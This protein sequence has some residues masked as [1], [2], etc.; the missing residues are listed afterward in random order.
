MCRRKP[1]NK[2]S[3][4]LL[5]DRSGNSFGK[6]H[7][8]DF[9]S[10]Q[11]ATHG[12]TVTVVGTYGYMPPEQ[13]GGKTTPAS[14]LY[15][16]GATLIYL[17]TKTHPAD[18]PSRSGFIRF[19]AESLVSA[20]F[21]TW[22]SYLIQPDVSQRFQSAQLALEALQNEQL[23]PSSHG[24]R[25]K[26]SGSRVILTKTDAQLKIVIPPLPVAQKLRVIDAALRTTAFTCSPLLLG[27]WKPEA[28]LLVAPLVLYI[29]VSFWVNYGYRLFAKIQVLIDESKIYFTYGWLGFK[30]K[31]SSSTKDII[32]LERICPPVSDKPDPINEQLFLYSSVDLWVGNK[33]HSLRRFNLTSVELDWLA[34]E[35]SEWLCLPIQKPG[36]GITLNSDCSS[37]TSAQ[38][39]NAQ[40]SSIE[41]TSSIQQTSPGEL[42]KVNRP[43]NALCYVD[44]DIKTIKISAPVQN[45]VSLQGCACFF[46]LYLLLLV[47][48]GI[49]PVAALILGAAP[50]ILWKIGDHQLNYRSRMA[51]TILQIDRQSISLW[52]QYQFEL[53]QLPHFHRLVARSTI[54]NR[55]SMS[56]WEQFQL[57]QQRYL[58]KK[59][60]RSTIHQLKLLKLLIIVFSK[61]LGLWHDDPNAHRPSRGY[62][63]ECELICGR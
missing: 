44:K 40:S 14:D 46:S 29:V 56:L 17:L 8:V 57:G 19:E 49:H 47:G 27:I 54:H 52:E 35:L 4:I 37:P 36:E 9:G 48:I 38:V 51:R 61:L 25:S 30:K 2:P 15:S 6:V 39:T 20:Q 34:V 10:V 33:Y 11:T 41:G 45:G 62:R 53:W 43:E 31:Y 28:G 1:H 12:G 60:P 59:M 18:L 32:K 22:L 7:L 5:G 3:N 24:V 42:A 16:L 55:Q 63:L 50:L 13:F 23:T 21:Q 58:L 26:P